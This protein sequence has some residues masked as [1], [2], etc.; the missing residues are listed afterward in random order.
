MTTPTKDTLLALL[1]EMGL[2]ELAENLATIPFQSICDYPGSDWIEFGM[3]LVQA[4]AIY[5]HLHPPA[6]ISADDSMDVDQQMPSNSDQSVSGGMHFVHE[7]EGAVLLYKSRGEALVGDVDVENVRQAIDEMYRAER[8]FFLFVEGS[9]GSG[10]TQLAMTLFHS[11]DLGKWNRSVI[12]LLGVQSGTNSQ[13]IYRYFHAITSLFQKCLQKDLLVH[14]TDLISL[15]D[16]KASN[17]A[18]TTFGFIAALL[19]EGNYGI[20]GKLT[21]NAIT[22]TELIGCVKSFEGPLPV[23]IIDEVYTIAAGQVTRLRLMRNAF[24]A[25]GIVVVLMGTDARAVN[26]INLVDISRDD[27][28]P[29]PWCRI[30]TKLPALKLECLNGLDMI[31]PYPQLTTLV[32]KSRPL[33]AL[34]ALELILADVETYANDVDLLLDKLFDVFKAYKFKGVNE[35]GKAA[36]KGFCLGQLALGISVTHVADSLTPA[37][38]PIIHHHFGRLEIS[39]CLPM[40]L[41]NDR[42]LR[43]ENT[44]WAPRTIFPSP[45]E[46]LLLH[47]TMNGTRSRHPIFD[48]RENMLSYHALLKRY[49]NS[50]EARRQ[51]QWRHFANPSQ[52]SNDGLLTEALLAAS[53]CMASRTGGVNGVSCLELFKNLVLQL[54][55][56][57][58]D[59]PNVELRGEHLLGQYI[60][61]LFPYWL[62][63]D[64]IIDNA[65]AG[66]FARVKTLRRAVN[67]ERVDLVSDGSPILLKQ[68]EMKFRGEA[69]YRSTPVKIDT[70]KAMLERVALPETISIV[71]TTSLQRNYF[72]KPGSFALFDKAHT[73]TQHLVL[74]LMIKKT[75]VDGRATLVAS[76][77]GI[78]GIPANPETPKG[79]VVFVCIDKWL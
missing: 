71:L 14:D 41:M 22:L 42:K 33:F 62:A 51:L 53:L 54:S 76:F 2:F 57:E 47:M 30:F 37:E 13:P 46:D 36:K 8:K 63:P 59:I 64:A 48:E 73:I 65:I 74:K 60:D 28:H 21:I 39:G 78:T 67:D 43:G 34:K 1:K 6:F 52:T 5:N 7:D 15:L 44:A 18:F 4:K 16:L 29:M 12:Y 61:L 20:N 10:K 55:P 56:D 77:S 58:E 17:L 31:K 45:S 24:L 35:G 49:M 3:N 66:A 40:T 79:L 75:L 27:D 9:S 25:A 38:T 23:V 69:K 70:M 26:L 19:K 72:K 32:V 11:K 68:T 50:P